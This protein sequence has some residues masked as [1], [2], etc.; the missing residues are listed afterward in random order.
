M[1]LRKALGIVESYVLLAPTEM[2]SDHMREV[3]FVSFASILG[4]LKPEANGIVAH[5]VEIVIRAADSLGG[6]HAVEIVGSGLVESGFLAK[7]REGLRGSWEA[8]QTTGPKKKHTPIDGIVETD[9][10][11]VL[12]RLALTNTRIFVTALQAVEISL[13]Q[14]FEATMDW[15]LTEWFS[16]FGNMGHP[17]QRKVNC[18]ALTRLLETNKR[19]IMGRLQDLMT[20]WTDVIT[21]LVDDKGVE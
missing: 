19:W 4:T 5:V 16:H 2:L 18:M 20:V 21:E 14:T 3:M 11:N 6:E 1:N 17:V 12:A 15:L 7:L 13:G 10:F 9:Y 8:H